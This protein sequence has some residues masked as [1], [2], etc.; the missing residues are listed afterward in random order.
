MQMRFIASL[1]P[2]F[3]YTK[4]AYSR[5]VFEGE[6][7]CGSVKGVLGGG[8]CIDFMENFLK[9]FLKFGPDHH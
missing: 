2:L 5:K 9:S 7:V 6:N 1:C 3:V 4:L 8:A